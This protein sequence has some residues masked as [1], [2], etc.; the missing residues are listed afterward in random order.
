MEKIKKMNEDFYLIVDSF[1]EVD[2]QPIHVSVLG[3]FAIVCKFVFDQ[4][5]QTFRITHAK[6]IQAKREIDI[7][8]DSKSYNEYKIKMISKTKPV[9]N[10][11]F[12]K[13]V[14]M[15]FYDD[16]IAN[17]DPNDE[18]FFKINQEGIS[19][20]KSRLV[21]TSKKEYIIDVKLFNEDLEE[22]TDKISFIR[23]HQMILDLG[24]H[25]C[26]FYI[27]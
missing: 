25:I 6:I 12:S 15:E 4:A 16:H 20:Y 18:S 24:N 7:Q 11:K 10:P 1:N 2:Y 5:N 19:N 9:K 8:K 23:K 26:R 13:L 22:K 3:D 21:G 27:I 14:Q 17:P